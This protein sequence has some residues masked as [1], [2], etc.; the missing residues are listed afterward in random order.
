MTD[1]YES[2]LSGHLRIGANRIGR[3]TISSRSRVFTETDCCPTGAAA[4]AISTRVSLRDGERE[5][6][7]PDRGMRSRWYEFANYFL[8]CR[9]LSF[10]LSLTRARILTNTPSRDVSP[11]SVHNTTYARNTRARTKSVMR[12]DIII[13]IIIISTDA[14]TSD[15]IIILYTNIHLADWRSYPKVIHLVP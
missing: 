3:R 2:L 14:A 9:I 8:L 7:I 5:T 6:T 13:I 15:Y 10:F 12:W 4:D 11:S 1:K